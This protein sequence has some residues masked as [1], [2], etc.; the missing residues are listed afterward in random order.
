MAVWKGAPSLHDKSS[1]SS[2]LV[3]PRMLHLSS[4][5]LDFLQKS[6]TSFVKPCEKVMRVMRATLLNAVKTRDFHLTS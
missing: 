5:I 3:T 2:S 4:K 1:P 6:S